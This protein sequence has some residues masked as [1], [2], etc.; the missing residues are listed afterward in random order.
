MSQE[1]PAREDEDV[2]S[3]RVR[4]AAVDRPEE[5][6]EDS[7]GRGDPD[8]LERQE[9]GAPGNVRGSSLLTGHAYWRCD[10][11]TQVAGYPCEVT[12]ISNR[13][14]QVMA[15]EQLETGTVVRLQIVAPDGAPLR[16]GSGGAAN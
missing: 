10:L 9:S 16:V 3:C 1:D 11:G 2:A 6:K 14:A 8:G 15:R 5:Q 13:G 7:R 12:D 4:A